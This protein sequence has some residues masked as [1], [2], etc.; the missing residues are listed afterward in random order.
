MKEYK[1]INPK[2]GLSR[3]N[4]KLEELLNQYARE[5][6]RLKNINESFTSLILERDKMR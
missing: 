2:L 4:D 3:R 1:V 6:W 5:G